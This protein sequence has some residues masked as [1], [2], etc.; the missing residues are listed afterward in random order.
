MTG[1]LEDKAAIRET[2]LRYAAG[3]DRKDWP[4]MKTCF[5]E[6]CTGV[7]NGVELN[8]SDAIVAY[9]NQ[10]AAQF[11]VLHAMHMLCNIHVELDGDSASVETYAFSS[12]TAESDGEIFLRLRGLRYRDTLVRQDG[13]W[14]IKHRVLSADWETR[15]PAVIP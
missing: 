6:D 1:A 5:T 13:D 7:W 10:A 14:L 9:I 2:L 8:G 15:G 3:V 11:T 4:L 12:L